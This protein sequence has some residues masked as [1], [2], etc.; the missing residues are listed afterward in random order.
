MFIDTAR[1]SVRAGNGG[2]GIVSFRRERFVDRGGPD[3]GDGGKGG[4]VIAIGDANLDGLAQYRFTKQIKAQDGGAGGK[5][6]SH[7]ANGGDVMLKVPLGT[8]VWQ[9]GKLLLDIT[10]AG[11]QAVIAKGGQGGFGNA[12]FVSSRRQAPTV[13]EVG[14]PGEAREL[15]LELKLIADVGLVGLPNAG[16]S[17]FLATV[18]SARPKIA[19]YPFTTLAPN[20]GVADIDGRSLLLADIPGLIEGASHGKGLG[21][22]F[23]RHV[24]R[25]AVLLHLID[26]TQEDPAA[27]YH[28]IVNE[29]KSYRVDLSGRPQTVVLTKDD[30]VDA[31]TLT[32]RRKV[33]DKAV[34]GKVWT[35][36]S[37][38][39]EGTAELL[40]HLIA[41]VKKVRQT[42]KPARAAR[43]EV[44]VLGLEPSD[45][46]WQVEK[47][48]GGYAVSGVKIER[49]AAR[50][51]FANPEGV[52]RLRDIMRRLGIMHE[53]QRRS[54]RPGD[55]VR[56]GKHGHLEY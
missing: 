43:G 45:D 27:S 12:H 2:R 35:I 1:I 9:A 10:G 53:L 19:D 15:R 18:T 4:D 36:S 22:E 42:K 51:D 14:E 3:G 20:L 30:A 16:K 52:K 56:I 46:T 44:P 24:E 29:L 7:G 41:E 39:R 31:R 6:R 55:T 26:A 28:T 8:E 21:V 34:G 13:A 5:Q 48:A 37:V 25:T 54:A 11:Q 23:L 47:T 33:L 40:R 38:K 50:T 49:F 32:A 17:T